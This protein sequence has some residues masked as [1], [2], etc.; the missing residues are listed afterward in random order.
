MARS[1]VLDVRALAAGLVL[2]SLLVAGCA[3][4]RGQPAGPSPDAEAAASEEDGDSPFEDWSEVLDDTREIEGF[5]TLHL[6]RDNTLYLEVDPE[7]LDTD[8]GLMAHYSRGLGDLFVQEG[9]PASGGTQLLRLRRS[10]DDVYLVRRNPRFTAAEGSAMRASLEENVG[11]SVL[12]AFDI[13]SVHD[14]TGH[15]L[16]DVTD[17]FVSD[18]ANTSATL[19]AAYGDRPVS[20]DGDRSYVERVQGFPQNVEIDAFLTY[21]AG[22]PPAFGGPGLSDFRSIPIGVRYSL[23][24]LPEEPMERRPADLRV[25]HFMTA[26]QDFSRDRSTDPYDRFVHRWRLEKRDHTRELSPPVEPIVYYIDH[27]VPERYRPY[28]R[29]GIEAWNEAFRAAGFENAVAARE[30]PDDSTWSAEDVRY[31]TVRWTA[32]HNMGYAI[33]PSQVDPRSGE[34]LNADILISSEFVQGWLETYEELVPASASPAAAG[35]RDRRRTRRAT[36]P[37]VRSGPAGMLLRHRE[38]QEALARTRPE[39]LPYLCMAESFR[40]QQLGTLYA[41]LAARGLLADDGEMPEEYFGAALKDLVMHEVGHT[42]GLRHNFRGSTDIPNDRLHDRDYTREHGVSLSVMEYAPVNLALEP[43]EQGHFWNPAVGSYDEWAITYAY[44]PL[45]EQPREGPIARSGTVASASDVRADVLSKIAGLS[46]DEHHA[47]A[48]DED[49]RFGPFAVDPTANTGDLGSDPLDWARDRQRIVEDVMP[50]LADRLV[51]EGESW[52][53]LRDGVTSLYFTKWTS[54]IPATKAIGGLYVVRDHR[55]QPGAR[56]PFRIVPAD[57]Q[58]EALRLL[59]EEAFSEDA[60]DVEPA[61]LNRLAPD[62]WFDWRRGFTEM[63]P[64]DYPVHRQVLSFQRFLLED[65]LHP[66]RLHRVVD[67]QL[68]TPEDVEPFTLGEL[69]GTLTGS[70]WSEI[71]RPS[72]PEEVASTRRNLQRAHLDR[73]ETLLLRESLAGPGGEISVP[74]DARALARAE[75]GDLA[76]RLEGAVAA[77]GSLSRE[78][79]A[80]LEESRARVERAL[81]ASLTM[82]AGE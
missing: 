4:G 38:A 47:Y 40:G 58:R 79:R 11:H 9:L 64:I 8:F 61:T 35:E 39:A 34:I 13:E 43:S 52:H 7:R 5:F 62:Q 77:D 24:A 20:L 33:G 22:D 1:S 76:R 63:L 29:E 17:F 23:F 30:A 25:G 81:E 60:F 70:I 21:E 28:V 12:A 42:L 44:V 49:A 55:G 53:R 66:E 54:L 2:A 27:S 41:V 10:G 37:A 15:L 57:R 68:R 51:A 45:Y 19:E 48:T 67:N 14:S 36:S 18:Y 3:S 50:G 56:P 32:A 74:Q 46:D 59:A 82:S 65:L 71:E 69:F 31:S 73:L 72:A 80:H 75:L 26:Q 16:V 78:T 6:K